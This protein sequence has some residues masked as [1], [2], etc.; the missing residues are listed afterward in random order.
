MVDAATRI[1]WVDYPETDDMGEHELQRFISELLRELLVTWLLVRMRVAHVGANQFFYWVLG[2]IRVCRAPDVYVVDGVA[3]NVPPVATWKTWEGHRPA[4]ALEVVSAKWKKDYEEAPAD[5]DAMGAKEL[6]IF[7]PWATARSRKR[8]RW[9]V[10]RQVRGRGLRRVEVSSGDRVYSKELGA[11]LRR[12]EDDGQVRLRVGIG[13]RGNELLPTN[14]EIAAHARTERAILAAQADAERG[15]R[16]AAEENARAAEEN[17][18]AAEEN[19]KA[20]EENARAAEAAR[21]AAEAEV[22]RLRRELEALRR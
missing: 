20:A 22:A 9:Q 7:D 1:D 4:F 6:V 15:A 3:Q 13:D 11:W 19:A 12:V 18:R 5:Y 16:Q 17:A 14:Q 21:E 10:F 2:D 8:V